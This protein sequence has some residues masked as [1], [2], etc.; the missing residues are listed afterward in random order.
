MIAYGP[1]LVCNQC[2]Y[3]IE[4]GVNI[5]DITRVSTRWVG[6]CSGIHK[7]AQTSISLLQLAFAGPRPYLLGGEKWALCIFGA[8]DLDGGTVE[9]TAVLPGFDSSIWTAW[10]MGNE[11]EGHHVNV[12]RLSERLEEHHGVSRQM[13]GCA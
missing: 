7:K 9:A 4:Q 3:D 11:G 2:T 13:I 12:D 5:L 6:G 8:S 1:I 10:E